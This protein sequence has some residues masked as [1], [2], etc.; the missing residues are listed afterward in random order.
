MWTER[1]YNYLKAK[2][3]FG[4]EARK[5]T[6]GSAKLLLKQR[7]FSTIK[8]IHLQANPTTSPKRTFL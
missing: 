2:W 7:T 1:L 8:A 6:E 4:P 5:I 3:D